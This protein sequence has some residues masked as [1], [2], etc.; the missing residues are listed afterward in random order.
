MALTLR[1]RYRQATAGP[2]ARR[3]SERAAAS[4]LPAVDPRMAAAP[5]TRSVGEEG[6]EPS[7]SYEQELLK[8]SR[9][10]LL[11]SPASKRIRRATARLGPNGVSP[12]E[13]CRVER[14]EYRAWR[15]PLVRAARGTDAPDDGARVIERDPERQ[16]R[17]LA[18]HG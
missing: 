12:P 14:V 2:V 15:A 6:L 5:L 10:P 13:Q 1:K 9:L 7:R 18:L 11:H 16:D 8:L 3:G 4:Y 17:L